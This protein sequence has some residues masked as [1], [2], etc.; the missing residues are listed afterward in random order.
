MDVSDSAGEVLE[1][2]FDLA[3]AN[4]H[5]EVRPAHLFVAL[6]ESFGTVNPMV[7]TMETFRDELLDPIPQAVSLPGPVLP[8]S[9]LR[10]VWKS[11]VRHA[12]DSGTGYVRR[13]DILNGLAA[14][15]GHAVAEKATMLRRN[16]GD[17]TDELRSEPSRTAASWHLSWD[18]AVREATR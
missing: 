6:L 9:R 16:L 3:S 7:I 11:A 2:A 1:A 10:A 5:A 14:E 12:G 15:G 17:L 4:Q 18:D 8:S 13:L